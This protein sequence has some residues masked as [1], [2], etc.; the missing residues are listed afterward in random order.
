MKPKETIVKS[1]TC[2]TRQNRRV[3]SPEVALASIFSLFDKWWPFGF[4]QFKLG[5]VVGNIS[6]YFS[7]GVVALSA[8]LRQLRCTRIMLQHQEHARTMPDYFIRQ[9]AAG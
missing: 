4:I 9:T 8:V 7:H 1:G 2:P 6:D 5:F 3:A